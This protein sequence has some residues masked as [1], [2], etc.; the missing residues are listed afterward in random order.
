MVFEKILGYL[1][2]FMKHVYTTL[3]K[4]GKA[5]LLLVIT[6]FSFSCVS[7]RTLMIEIP[8]KAKNE[9]P[10]NVQS[11]LLLTRVYNDSY[12]DLEADSLQKLFYLQRFNYDTVINDMR[13]IDTTL[14][15][16]GELLFESGRYDFVIP[17]DRFQPTGNSVAMAAEMPAEEIKRRC[18]TYKTDAVLS[19]DFIK[20][21]VMTE[22][23]QLVNF[24]QE[25][26]SFY[27]FAHAEMKV[28]YEALFRIYD[29]DKEGVIYR[30]FLRDTI[31]WEASDRTTSALFSHFTPVKDAL[32]ET[33]IAIA[34]DVSAEIS[35]AWRTEFRKYFVSGHDNLKLAT[36]LVD[37][38]QWET[39]IALWKNLAETE[40]KKSVK[41][42]A[43]FNLA[44]AYEMTGDI[45][46]AIQW[47][48]K[49]FETMYR[50]Q[51]FEYL[52][53]L[54]YR[55]NELQKLQP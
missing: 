16:L 28:S 14:K 40:K 42:K 25:S 24:D 54:K 17:E 52:E 22:Y 55:K 9:L 6:L 26:N 27:D 29:A 8:E 5:V 38:S 20:T 46:T 2:N 45:D 53:I 30:K 11:I 10:E 47:G 15:A 32:A 43:E 12:T 48:L 4:T 19:L 41:S 1:L 44:V 18:E 7:V 35:P 33:G 23:D 31:L 39:A 37:S 21:R 13:A 51:T 36:A 34:L 50:T 3:Q 49:S